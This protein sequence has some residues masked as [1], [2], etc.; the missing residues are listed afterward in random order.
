[1]YSLAR[2]KSKMQWNVIAH[3][4]QPVNKQSVRYCD[5]VAGV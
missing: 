5:V 4:E 3:I 1:M 2:I